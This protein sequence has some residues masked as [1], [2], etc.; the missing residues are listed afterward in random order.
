MSLATLA[1]AVT[2]GA[3]AALSISPDAMEPLALMLRRGYLG[4]AIPAEAADSTS[5]ALEYLEQVRRYVP[6][7]LDNSVCSS[8]DGPRCVM[9]GD[10]DQA[11]PV[12]ADGVRFYPESNYVLTDGPS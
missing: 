4:E 12:F 2:P 10:D 8:I 7:V 3:S 6:R 5:T 1:V 11:V 9:L